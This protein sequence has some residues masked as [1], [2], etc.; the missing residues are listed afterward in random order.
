M[1]TGLYKTIKGE[2]VELTAKQVKA[3]IMK[4]RGWTSEE[5]QRQYDI[6]RNQLRAYEGFLR[7]KGEFVQPESPAAFLF[8]EA[9]AIQRYGA[10]YT[11][12][13][14]TAA[15]RATTSVSSGKALTKLLT[16]KSKTAKAARGRQYR[17]IAAQTQRNFARF[18][19]T[20]PKAQEI[21]REINDPIKQQRALAALADVLHAR[22]NTQREVVLRN[23]DMPFGQI[24]GSQDEVDF[25][26]YRLGYK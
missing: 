13:Q 22:E 11:P 5:Y 15:V 7:Q 10:D 12:S 16:S 9:K 17:Q 19:E 8:K 26:I 25:D 14:R 20:V 21:M 6:T 4:I 24:A 2:K 1:A 18:I 23:A 3:D